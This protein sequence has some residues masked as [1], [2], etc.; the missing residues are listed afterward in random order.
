MSATYK[1]GETPAVGDVVRVG[2]GKLIWRVRTLHPATHW[3]RATASL[4]RVIMPG[5]PW[6]RVVS[7]FVE[8]GRLVLVTP[9][10]DAERA[11]TER[12]LAEVEVEGQ[13]LRDLAQARQRVAGF[14]DSYDGGQYDADVI[15]DNGNHRLLASD[16]RALLAELAGGDL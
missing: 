9:A 2:N 6:S 4:Q 1:T 11:E 10:S 12:K 14:V 8:Y 16:L 15:H 3:R 13:R 5:D 7:N